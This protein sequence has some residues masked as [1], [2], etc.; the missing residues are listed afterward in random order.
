MR[1]SSVASFI[2]AS[3]TFTIGSFLIFYGMILWSGSEGIFVPYASLGAI[4]VFM[5]LPTVLFG[6]KTLP[7]WAT[8][9]QSSST[10]GSEE[11]ED[12]LIFSNKRIVGLSLLI[13]GAVWLLITLI[14]FFIF[15]LNTP[16]AMNSCPTVFT[17]FTHG[18]LILIGIGVV[19][20][21]AGLILLAMSKSEGR[22]DQRQARTMQ[23][24]I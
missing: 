3:L 16:C 10:K 6:F 7:R 13:T 14:A 19:I 5:S 20:F 2:L 23:I 1:L 12:S 21:A 9:R 24:K 8:G 11:Y 17:L 4:S 15:P 22:D 18:E